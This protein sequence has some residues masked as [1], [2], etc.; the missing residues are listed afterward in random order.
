MKK[1]HLILFIALF[2]NLTNAQVDN[3]ATLN[4]TFY[5]RSSSDNFHHVDQSNID[6]N[7]FLQSR[8]IL[9]KIRWDNSMGYKTI[10][11]DGS[12]QPNLQDLFYN[13]NFVYT[14][15]M[16]NFMLFNARVNLRTE[17]EN[18]ISGSSIFPAFSFGYMR[19]SQTNKSIRWGIGINY[20]NDFNKNTVIPFGL[21]NYETAKIKFN[22]TLPNS[23]LFLVKQKST[24]YYGINATLNA[25]I[26]GLQ[27]EPADYLKMIN[28][29]LFGFVQTK[30]HNKIWVDLKPGFTIYRTIEG[31]D[32][33]FNAFS[34]TSEN[35]LSNNFV[36]NVGLMYRM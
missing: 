36:M 26:F 22:A 28:A 31:L 9:K 3:N 15:N 24:F 14:K 32:Q 12:L 18:N 23:I 11:L 13:A 29:N 17:I 25:G 16:K 35:K 21:F 27:N 30:I 1:I 6:F 8:K 7:Y 19:Q 33:D 34:K 5:N 4:Y 20:N 10:F 2:V